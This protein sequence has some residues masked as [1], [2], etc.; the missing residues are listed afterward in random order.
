MTTSDTRFQ[1][2]EQLP[3]EVEARY[4]HQQGGDWPGQRG[5]AIEARRR[6][7]SARVFSPAFPTIY[8][9]DSIDVDMDEGRWP[10]DE[11]LAWIEA[12]R[13]QVIDAARRVRQ[14]TVHSTPAGGLTHADA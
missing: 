4:D 11:F 13:P 1:R 10:V 6:S 7:D 9:S 12:L 3:I 8:I 5:L 2:I 14:G